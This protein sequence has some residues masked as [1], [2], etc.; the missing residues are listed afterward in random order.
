MSSAPAAVNRAVVGAV[1][2]GV[3]LLFSTRSAY[4]H[5]YPMMPLAAAAR[6]AGHEVVFSI[7]PEF[8][9][10]LEGLGY[11]AYATGIEIREAGAA[12]VAAGTPAMGADG[13]TNLDFG[14][15]VFVDVLAR[16]VADDLA[17][18]LADV[19]PDVVVYGQFD[20][21]AGIAAA[22][23]GIPVICHAISP[24]WPIE[25]A[26]S[27]F[28]TRLA[29]LCAEHGLAPCRD[30]FVGDSYLAVFPPV[31]EVPSFAAHPARWPMRP[32]AWTEPGASMPTWVQRRRRPL[33][34]V[35]L[36][37]MVATD[38][39]LRPVIEGVAQLDA[40]VLV[41]LGSA[42]GT[43]IGDL[44]AN[45]HVE[46]FVDQASVLA[47]ADLVVHHGGSGTVLAALAAGVPQVVIP[48]GADQFVNADRLA[49][50]GLASVL[51]PADAT[52]AA[53]ATAAK[54][55]KVDNGRSAAL[56]LRTEIAAMSQPATIVGALADR[57][58]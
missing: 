54:A 50:T 15:H 47:V 25:A 32:V 57:Y 22:A 33:V 43:G 29:R 31:L 39:A 49:V 56:D 2:F 7:G 45:V 1:V 18:V 16:R 53:V 41:A 11:R 8:V 5:L 19:E 37:T 38:D 55:A 40:D 28:A 10:K 58:G 30:G 17:S 3:R 26:W 12:A 27:T 13:R 46:G 14:A 6:A 34:Y 24:H 35:T 23:A 52:P 9:P 48:K 44:P 4:G 20:P 21:G 51:L 42:A 36:G